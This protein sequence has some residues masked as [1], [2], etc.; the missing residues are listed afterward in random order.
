M[1]VSFFHHSI[2]L[3]GRYVKIARDI[4]QTP[5]E[6]STRNVQDLLSQDIKQ[7]VF[8]SDRAVLHACGREDQDVRMLGS[9]RP[10]CL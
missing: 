3:K 5:W 1:D 2:I 4:S 10:F 6:N 9:G 8:G 7:Q